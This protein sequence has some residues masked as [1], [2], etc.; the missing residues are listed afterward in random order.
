M[1]E[2]EWIT[3]LYDI[4]EA[5]QM[6]ISAF[7]PQL[8][9]VSTEMLDVWLNEEMII[10]IELLNLIGA[11]AN[12]DRAKLR[13]VEQE[14]EQ[15]SRRRANFVRAWINRKEAIFDEVNEYIMNHPKKRDLKPEKP[16]KGPSLEIKAGRVFEWL[17]RKE[18]GATKSDLLRAFQ[19][20]KTK[21]IME[22]LGLLINENKITEEKQ[23]TLGQLGRPSIIY[24]VIKTQ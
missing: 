13:G 24:K 22:V 23:E 16:S 5:R 3:D 10:P 15:S 2:N 21:G 4:A 17:S 18:K 6:Q 7:L 19:G 8:G 11:L 14:I 20:L 9:G 12:E 1:L